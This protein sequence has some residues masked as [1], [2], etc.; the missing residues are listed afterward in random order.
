MKKL[1]FL[2]MMMFMLFGAIKAAN[3]GIH[4]NIRTLEPAKASVLPILDGS[5]DDEVWKTAAMVDDLAARRDWRTL[6]PDAP[7]LLFQGELPLPV[8]NGKI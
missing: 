1:L 5:L 6:L 2:I 8:L 7:E 4:Q 3:N